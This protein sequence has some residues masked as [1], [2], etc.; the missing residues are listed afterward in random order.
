[1]RPQSQIFKNITI[2]VSAV[3][4]RAIGATKPQ[5]ALSLELFDYLYTNKSLIF[6]TEINLKHNYLKN[7]ITNVSVF[8]FFEW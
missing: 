7:I 6:A 3:F 2:F 8:L 1:M 5:H 4:F